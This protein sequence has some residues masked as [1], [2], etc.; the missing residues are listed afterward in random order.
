MVILPIQQYEFKIHNFLQE[1]NFETSTT[2]P[3][4]TFQTRKILRLTQIQVIGYG[5]RDLVINNIHHVYCIVNLQQVVQPDDG[6]YR[7]RN[8]LLLTASVPP[9]AYINP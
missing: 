3:T 6:Q 5:E 7:G 9:L 4:E 8:M 2:D 1:N